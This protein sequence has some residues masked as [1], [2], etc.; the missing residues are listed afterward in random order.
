MNT[1]SRSP[2]NTWIR[3]PYPRPQALA[4]LVCLPHA[5]GGASL[6]HSWGGRIS[7]AIEVWAI[8]LPGRGSRFGE[9][10]E[11]NLSRVVEL[12]S[13]TLRNS[14]L[15]A[16]PFALFG[17]SMGGLVG[18]ELARAFQQVP[19]LTHLFA[20]GCHAPQT[21]SDEQPIHRL[22]PKQFLEQMM[23]RYNGIP[24]E[25]AN[26]PELVDLLLPVLQSDMRMVETH[27]YCPGAP[28][29]CP[30]TV[31]TGTS[32]RRATPEVLEGWKEQTK[33]QF[34][35]LRFEGGH[36]FLQTATSEVLRVVEE[37][38]SFS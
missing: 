15:F 26:E 31:L 3:C 25:I 9:P 38:F 8:E 37:R 2:K 24:E 14:G 36:F 6:Y 20:S 27:R 28:L 23:T 7:S 17:H 29:S 18:F 13:E 16:K 5:G 34:D 19:Q 1:L 32:D 11:D 4:R 35:L 30:I 33:S 21:E 12:L 22:P 10:C